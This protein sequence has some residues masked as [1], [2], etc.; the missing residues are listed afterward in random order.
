MEALRAYAQ[1]ASYN[2]DVP[3]VRRGEPGR[4]FYLVVSGQLEVQ[5]HDRERKLVLTRLGQGSSFGEM[6]LLTGDPVSADV[7]T[8]EQAKILQFSEENFYKALNDSEALR[9]H[10][11]IRLSNNLRRTSSEAWDLFQHIEAL[12]ALM[13]RQVE[14]G[15]IIAESAVMEKIQNQIEEL[16]QNSQPLLITGEPGTGKLFAAKTIHEAKGKTA[17]PLIIVD[18]REIS[19]DTANKILFGS[20]EMYE[21]TS[22]SDRYSRTSLQVQGALHLADQGSLVLRHIDA[23]QPAEQKFLLHYLQLIVV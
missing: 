1:E 2:A 8:L 18:C 23:L 9:N 10:V 15:S 19:G 12:N 21:F 3:V 16:G 13:L 20:Q 11:L 4:M 17:T 14:E 7:V 6:S 22:R 5:L